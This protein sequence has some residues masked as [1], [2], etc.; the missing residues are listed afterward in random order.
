MYSTGSGY[1]DLRLELWL[2]FY[3]LRLF[4]CLCEQN[5]IHLL[6]IK[7]ITSTISAQADEGPRLAI[8]NFL[9]CQCLRVNLA[10]EFEIIENGYVLM[11]TER[12]FNTICIVLT[13]FNKINRNVMGGERNKQIF[14][15]NF[16]ILYSR[17]FRWNIWQAL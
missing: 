5:G 7:Q 3:K 1:K 4:G 15:T 12:L 13:D 10:E 6:R 17:Y 8:P 14:M 9:S 2:R 16:N 11:H